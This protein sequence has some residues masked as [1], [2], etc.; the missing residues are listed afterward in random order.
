MS[1]LANEYAPGS[2][3]YAN[4]AKTYGTAAADEAYQVARSGGE[5]WEITAALNKYRPQ[6]AEPGS[7]STFGNFWSQITT[8]PLAAPLESANNHIGNAIL[9]VLKN[10][11]VLLVLALL[12]WWKLGFPGAPALKKHFA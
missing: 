9:G 8:D 11:W 1:N 5:R 3:K 10:P 7:T 12:V 2:T 6:Y 4:L